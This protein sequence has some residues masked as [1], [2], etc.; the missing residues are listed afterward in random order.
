[1][2]FNSSAG[3]PPIRAAERVMPSPLAP[4]HLQN[5]VG[6]VRQANDFYR[7]VAAAYRA[8]RRPT[9]HAQK[10]AAQMDLRVDTWK[11]IRCPMNRISNVAYPLIDMSLGPHTPP[12][13]SVVQDLYEVEAAPVIP[14]DI[15]GVCCANVPLKHKPSNLPPI[16]IPAIGSERRQLPKASSGY[17]A[18]RTGHGNPSSYFSAVTPDIREAPV[19]NVHVWDSNMSLQHTE[20]VVP[21][22][23]AAEDVEMDLADIVLTPMS[24]EAED[25]SYFEDEEE[26]E[27]RFRYVVGGT[28]RPEPEELCYPD[29]DED[30]SPSSSGTSGS[31]SSSP[32]SFSSISTPSEGSPMAICNKRK[33]A[34]YDEDCTRDFGLDGKPPKYLRKELA[35]AQPVPRYR[36]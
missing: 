8:A 2:S 34:Y 27:D 18:S 26:D 6:I 36:V 22:D 32:S 1:M 25:G 11:A 23:V 21:D 20:Q 4:H 9:Y 3:L 30:E 17:R 28:G 7:M 29:F 19:F 10:L 35:I 16:I 5:L 15:P 31:D 14:F 24:T 12:A 33:P 13:R